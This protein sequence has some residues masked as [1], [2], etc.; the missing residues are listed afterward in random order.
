MGFYLRKSVKVGPLRFNLSK[1]GVGVSAGIKGLRIGTGP[2]GNYIH[3]GRGGLYYRK[4]IPNG[5]PSRP[6]SNSSPASEAINPPLIDDTHEPLKEI[7]SGSI[8]DMVDSSSK[9]LVDELNSKRKKIRL[10]P[11]GAVL[12]LLCVFFLS[13]N[14]FNNWVVYGTAISFSV[15]TLFLAYRDVLTKSAVILYNVEDEF[16]QLY[17]KMHDAFNRM[18]DCRK[19]W[20][21]EA[22]G[23]VKDKK[24]H[25]GADNIVKRSPI[26]LTL[27]NPP[28]VKTNIATPCIPVGKQTM[29]FFPDKVL[30]YEKNGVGA[31]SYENLE[32]LIGQSQFIEDERVPKDARVVGQT[33]KYVNKRGGPDK[34]FKDNRQIPI[35]LYDDVHFHSNTG[36]NERIQLSRA[37]V[38]SS[39]ANAI[40][41]VGQTSKAYS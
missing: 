17:Q 19:V 6:R 29:Y 13:N 5:A 39:F 1:S 4:T 33:W 28:F 41:E 21:L 26:S 32:V 24:Y 20:H 37:N 7:E 23:K 34:R 22:S 10:W 2:R 35:A 14:Q 8:S 30:V 31:V 9:E 18:K 27:K 25:A 12:G 3:M 15:L 40:L 16:E 38:S 36:L 11:I